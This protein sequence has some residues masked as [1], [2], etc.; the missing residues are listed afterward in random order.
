MIAN[1]SQAIENEDETVSTARFAIR[2]QKLVNQVSRNTR[3]DMD[4]A[5]LKL[6]QENEALKAKI[7]HQN[8]IVKQQNHLLKLQMSQGTI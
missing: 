6:Q 2:C 4:I 1:V 7:I 5:F 3:V 8:G